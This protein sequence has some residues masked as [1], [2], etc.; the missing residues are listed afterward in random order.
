MLPASRFRREAD[1]A[2]AKVDKVESDRECPKIPL[3][4]RWPRHTHFERRPIL[5]TKNGLAELRDSPTILASGDAFYYPAYTTLAGR[6]T[7]GSDCTRSPGHRWHVRGAAAR[8][9]E[10]AR[11][12]PPAKFRQVS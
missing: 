10:R 2:N 5:Q 3:C 6:F 1:R 11:R 4:S 8:G 12:H 7:H 9:D